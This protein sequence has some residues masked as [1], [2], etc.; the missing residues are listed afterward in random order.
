MKSKQINVLIVDDHLLV[1]DGLTHLLADAANIKVVAEACNG[2]EAVEIIGHIAVDIVLMDVEMPVMNGWDATRLIVTRYPQTKVI[3]LTT[4]S[5]KAIVNKM[6][7]AGASGYL[8]KNITR[9][10]LHES[11]NKVFRGEQFLSSEISMNLLKPSA[12]DILSPKKQAS[13]SVGLLS[14]REIEILKLIA[15]GL[16]NIEIAE[17]LFISQ[18][19]VRVH[20]ENIMKKLDLHNVVGLVRF[21]ID[22]GLVD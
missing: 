20:R 7:V 8:L 18:K 6:M 9:E 22:N 2:K 1:R 4:F 19:T 5:E 11:I 12:E 10:I 15:G 14:T 17:K 3:A 16:A 13:S 21:A